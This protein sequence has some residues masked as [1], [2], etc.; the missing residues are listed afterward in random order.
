MSSTRPSISSSDLAA[1][2]TEATLSSPL[3]WPPHHRWCHLYFLWLELTPLLLP[4]AETN[5]DCGIPNPSLLLRRPSHHPGAA[6]TEVKD[7]G[8]R[9]SRAPPPLAPLLPCAI[10]GNTSLYL[11]PGGPCRWL[12]PV[13]C[14]VCFVHWLFF[15]AKLMWDLPLCHLFWLGLCMSLLWFMSLFLCCASMPCHCCALV[16]WFLDLCTDPYQWS[17]CG[18]LL[19]LMAA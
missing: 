10:F 17:S 6:S 14:L 1:I 11:W 4:S 5:E 2:T 18:L 7:V 3:P 19:N 8:A 16:C 15:G 12:S 13:P 9:S